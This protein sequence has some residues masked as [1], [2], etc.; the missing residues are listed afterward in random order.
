[1][2]DKIGSLITLEG[3]KWKKNNNT[4]E[5]LQWHRLLMS[6]AELLQGNRLQ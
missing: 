6:A 3:Q 1:M 2:L 4:G 5:L